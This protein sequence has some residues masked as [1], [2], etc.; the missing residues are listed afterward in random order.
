MP[1]TGGLT[2]VYA[3]QV[4]H[5]VNLS[6]GAIHVGLQSGGFVAMVPLCTS[7]M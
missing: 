1:R 6:G 4:P 3:I 5:I 2:K 7:L